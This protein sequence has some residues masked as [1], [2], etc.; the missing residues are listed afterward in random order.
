MEYE[1]ERDPD[2]EPSLA[3]MTSTAIKLLK[4]NHKGFFLLVEGMLCYCR[5]A[6]VRSVS[7][8]LLNGTTIVVI[9]IMVKFNLSFN[10]M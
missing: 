8:L 9:A 2:N 1:I 6:N 5:A 7:P 4:R 3:Q 10:L